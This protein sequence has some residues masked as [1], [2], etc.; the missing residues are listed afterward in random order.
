[1]DIN[2]RSVEYRYVFKQVTEFA[3]QTVMDMGTGKTALPALIKGCGVQVLA[4]DKDQEQ[5]QENP[6]TRGGYCSF[7][8]LQQDLLDIDDN[9]KF[10]MILCISVLEHNREHAS[11]MKKMSNLLSP[12]GVI[13]V[14]FPYKEDEYVPNSYQLPMAGYGRDAGPDNICQMY[15]REQLEAWQSDCGLELVDQEY[16]QAFTGAYWTY[17]Q[18]MWPLKQTSKEETHQLTCVTFRKKT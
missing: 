12:S 6:C 15:S 18:R 9:N 13:V 14:T 5:I 3:P 4:V 16:W 11:V 7:D 10:D 1:M 8:I 2:E 17:G